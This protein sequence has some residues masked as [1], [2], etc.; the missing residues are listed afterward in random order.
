MV[1]R[2]LFVV[3]VL[4]IAIR[5]EINNLK[6]IGATENTISLSVTE[7]KCLG[8]Y[9]VNALYTLQIFLGSKSR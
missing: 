9:V 6:V 1:S 3:F 7:I 8:R 5:G 4:F 2:L